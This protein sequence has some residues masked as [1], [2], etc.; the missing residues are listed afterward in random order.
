MRSISPRAAAGEGAAL[1]AA[2]PDR[3]SARQSRPPKAGS[4]NPR[5]T[6]SQAV[7]R[8]RWTAKRA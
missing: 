6:A 4:T 3:R 1:T 5:S 2:R 7:Y 8:V